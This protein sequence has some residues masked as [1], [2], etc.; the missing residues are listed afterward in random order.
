MEIAK[1][2]KQLRINYGI[3]QE[4]LAAKSNITRE[5]ISHAENGTRNPNKYTILQINDALIDTLFEK[6]MHIY[7]S[8][9]ET[10]K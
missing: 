4:A 9:N 1:R 10:N 5:T 2:N 7:K 6:F 8:Y 3:T